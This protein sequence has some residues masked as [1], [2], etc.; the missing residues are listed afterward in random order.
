MYSYLYL[1]YSE[2]PYLEKQKTSYY[3]PFKSFY[4]KLR[5]YSS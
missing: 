2:N 5:F 1:K 3:N 4:P